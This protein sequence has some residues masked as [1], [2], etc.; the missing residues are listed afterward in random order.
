VN[1]VGSFFDKIF[2]RILAPHGVCKPFHEYNLKND[3][4]GNPLVSECQKNN[5]ALYYATP[6]AL[7]LFKAIYHNDLGMQDKYV[8]YWAYLSK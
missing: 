3:T 7:T 5:F 8:A 2:E 6:E 1:C 4:D